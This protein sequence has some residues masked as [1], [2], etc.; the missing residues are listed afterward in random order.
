[1]IIM[2]MPEGVIRG[3]YLENRLNFPN[4]FKWVLEKNRER[5]FVFI[6]FNFPKKLR[7]SGFH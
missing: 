1:M 2:M 5:S 6:S 7:F 3:N 4:P